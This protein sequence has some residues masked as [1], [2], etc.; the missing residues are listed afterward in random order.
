[1]LRGGDN[2]STGV[3]EQ[4]EHEAEDVSSSKESVLRLRIHTCSPGIQKSG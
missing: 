3:K 1:M 2:A 4:G